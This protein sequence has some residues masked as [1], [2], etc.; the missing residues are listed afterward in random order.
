MQAF[1]YATSSEFLEITHIFFKMS[2]LTHVMGTKVMLCWPQEQIKGD[3]HC[4]I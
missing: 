1:E 4:K 3:G 2:T